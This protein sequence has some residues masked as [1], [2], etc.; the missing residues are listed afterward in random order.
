LSQ[1]D[2]KYV[3]EDWSQKLG[4]YRVGYSG[5]LTAR[6]QV[7]SWDQIAP[8]LPP[9]HLCGS[10][11]LIDLVEDHVREFLLNPEASLLPPDQVEPGANTACMQVVPE[12][13]DRIVNELVERGLLIWL[14]E[15][16]V[17]RHLGEKVTN[18]LFGVG[19]NKRLQDGREV[20]RLIMNLQPS[21]RLQ[22]HWPGDIEALPIWTQWKSLHLDS[23]SDLA[24]SSEDLQGCFYLFRLP[25]EWGGLFSFGHKRRGRELGKGGNDSEVWFH[26][27]AITLPMGWRNAMGVV[28][29]AHRCLMLRASEC[30]V[31]PLE[32][33]LPS[34]ELRK[35]R[36]VPA[37][38]PACP[39]RDAVYQVY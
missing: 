4:N 25:P 3:E 33:L 18:G 27:A 5:D 19:K 14:R 21:N 38:V 20:L 39:G 30:L 1:E 8:S 31:H 35:D 16:R 26:A 10:V 22:A 2:F 11:P 29:H 23:Y 37:L 28:Q 36:Q 24:S 15:D 34:Q 9:A 12:E 7:L 6:A 13:E 17:V 32:P